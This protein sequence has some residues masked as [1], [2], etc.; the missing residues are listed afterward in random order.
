MSFATISDPWRPR[1]DAWLR[2]APSAFAGQEG[3]PLLIG[4]CPRSGTTLLRSMLDNHPELAVP[5]ETNFVFDLWRYRARFGDLRDEANRRR[6]A[7]FVVD[8]E[9]RGA[10]RIRAGRSREETVERVAQAGPTVGSV[11]AAFWELYAE[12]KGKPRWGDKRPA[13]AGFI[14]VMFDL[15]PAAQFVNLVR[16][17]RGAVASTLR[18]DWDPE[19]VRL[20]SAIAT[21]E[22]S[23]QRVDR[24][25]R[26]L[27]PDQLLDV[28]Y[29]DLVR[30]PA[31]EL[32]RICVFAGLRADDEAIEQMITEKR[33]GQFREGWHERLN[34]PISTG[35]IDSWREKLGDGEVAVIE[36]ATKRWFPR[37]GYVAVA[38][39]GAPL[40]AAVLAELAHQRK[41]RTRKWRRYAIDELKRRYVVD[42]RPIAAV[43]RAAR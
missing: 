25:A 39:E 32:R 4:A 41:R 5:G 2:R 17:P 15:W 18:T 35:P 20:P 19:E 40:D 7:E 9:G 38:P 10:K 28:R 27:R 36:H 3:R 37:F 43:P 26:R 16:D 29:E 30:E 21:W 11:A 22:Q 34:E 13:Y 12:R 33:S 1:E 14:G 42:R 24:H 8:A 23:V 6:M 31:A